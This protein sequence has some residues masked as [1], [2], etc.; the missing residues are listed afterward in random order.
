MDDSSPKPFDKHE[1]QD[2]FEDFLDQI[3]IFFLEDDFS[4]NV[5]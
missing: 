2:A 4:Q 3:K 1:T 5:A